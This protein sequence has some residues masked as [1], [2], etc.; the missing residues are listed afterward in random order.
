[1]N[2]MICKRKEKESSLCSSFVREQQVV[3]KKDDCKM[4]VKTTLKMTTHTEC[5]K[6]DQVA[7]NVARIAE[8]LSTRQNYPKKALNTISVTVSGQLTKIR[9]TK[10]QQVYP[11]VGIG[12]QTT[13]RRTGPFNQWE[14]SVGKRREALRP[15]GQSEAGDGE[16]GLQD[17]EK[18]ISPTRGALV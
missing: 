13:P 4:T 18:Q 14:W 10:P 15:S 2:S 12:N 5:G 7:P 16:K 8:R 1:M 17:E 6:A 9:I 3:G 11:R